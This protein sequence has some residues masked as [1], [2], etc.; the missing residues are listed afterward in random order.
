MDAA[1]SDAGNYIVKDAGFG[2]A[3]QGDV[4]AIDP[5][6]RERYRRHYSA[7]VFNIGLSTCGRYA[8]VQTANAPW[9][10]GNLL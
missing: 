5:D 4:V 2:S 7:N 10:Y 8:A 3:L 1:V 9:Y 6:G